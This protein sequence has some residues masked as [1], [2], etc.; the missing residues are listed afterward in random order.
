MLYMVIE[1]FHDGAAPEIYKRFRENGR[2][3]P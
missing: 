2:M 1:H 3:M